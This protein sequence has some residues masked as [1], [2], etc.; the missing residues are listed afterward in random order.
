MESGGHAGSLHQKRMS[1]HSPCR[2]PSRAEARSQAH[3]ADWCREPHALVPVQHTALGGFARHN[4]NCTAIGHGAHC[5]GQR[6]ERPVVVA[7][8]G[9][10]LAK[11]PSLWIDIDYNEIVVEIDPDLL[12]V[13]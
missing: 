9:D 12:V 2:R 7:L 1:W 11:K 4:S 13:A 8:T 10:R 3:A 6:S 5:V